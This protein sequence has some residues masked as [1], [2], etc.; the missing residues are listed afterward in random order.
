MEVSHLLVLPRLR[1]Q[2][3]N[4][5]SSPITWGF[6]AMSAFVGL[7]RALERNKPDDMDLEFYRV[8]VICHGYEAQT[9]KYDQTHHFHQ[10]RKPL[11]RN[12][13][14]FETPP[15]QQEGRI[16]IDITLVFEVEGEACA[17][18]GMP[19][20]IA[21]M[22]QRMRIAGGSVLPA[23]SNK[24]E[25]R[26]YL[27]VIN[28]DDEQGDNAFRRL[29]YRWLPGFALVGRDDLL[30]AHHQKLREENPEA[31]RLGA[32]LDRVSLRHW[33][34]KEQV[35]DERDKPKEV[36]RWQ[37]QSHGPGWVVPIPVGYQAISPLFEP[38][39][40][41]SARDETTHTRFVE[42]VYS[43][44]QWIAPHRLRLA[45]DILWQEDNDLEKGLYRL[46]ND[47]CEIS[48]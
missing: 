46:T 24:R 12:N 30:R 37:T 2:N 39:A 5:I 4:A 32:L 36:V 45:T 9:M 8:G 10:M 21:E 40:M 1:V 43:L 13:A 17:D 7:M 11:E 29:C 48:R 15:W 19:G 16:H 6:P 38:G 41:E 22:V 33:C 28:Q 20:R 26:P 23:I 42:A 25:Y 31:S 27:A 14:T 34:E 18:K 47:Y 35:L 44:G 3:A